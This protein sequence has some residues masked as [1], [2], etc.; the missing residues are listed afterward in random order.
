MKRGV[1]VLVC[2][3]LLLAAGGFSQQQAAEEPA[4][5]EE[6][7]AAAIQALKE[8]WENSCYADF[9]P[10]EKYLEIKNTRLFVIRDGQTSPSFADAAYVVEFMLLSNYYRSAPLYMNVGGAGDTVVIKKDGTAEALS[11]NIFKTY[12]AR[13]YSSDLSDI[14]EEIH[15]LQDHYHQVISF[16]GADTAA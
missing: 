5:Y 2:C 9:A 7:I 14:I 16:D 1:L 11:V 6:Q 4:P 12:M 13:T 3:C 8:M 15:D 10:D